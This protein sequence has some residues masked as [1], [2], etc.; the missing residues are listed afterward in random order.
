M[1]LVDDIVSSGGTL[2][3]CAQ[4]LIAAGATSIDGVVTHALFPPA[5]MR[6]FERAG[7]RSLRST[8]SV[9]HPSNAIDLDRLLAAALAQGKRRMSLTVR[10][11]GAA[12]TVTGSCHLFEMDGRRILVDCGMF[13]G[14]KTLKAL[15]YGA[16]P[17]R[18]ADIDAVLLTHAHIDHSGLL[19][20]LVTAGF[21]GPIL[22]TQGTIDLCS[23]MLPDSGSIQELEVS[24]LNRRNAARGRDPVVPIYTQARRACLP[25]FVQAGRLRTMDR[26]AAR[27][28]RALLERR[29]SARLGLDRDRIH[30]RRPCL[31]A[32]SPPA[33]SAPTP[34]CFNPIRRRPPASI[35]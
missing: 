6:D 19:P 1:L 16:F 30:D 2:V 29:P 3:T 28:P 27:H 21:R 15:N 4:A 20:K 7:I 12:R 24:S 8:T 13:Q 34:S 11:C 32:C 22:A 33:T 25:R 26:R 31:R 9:P 18:P 23:F 17:F 14:Q 10:F 5:M 35:T